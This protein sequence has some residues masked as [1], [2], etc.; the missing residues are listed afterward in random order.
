MLKPKLRSL[1]KVRWNYIYVFQL[2]LSNIIS[3]LHVFFFINLDQ[4][5]VDFLGDKDINTFQSQ[6]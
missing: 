5:S 6:G 3:V 2:A 4:L 1:S